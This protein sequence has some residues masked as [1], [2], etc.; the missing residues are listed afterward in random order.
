MSRRA[1]AVG[2]ASA[3]AVCAGLA[4]GATGGG[5]GGASD[6]GELRDVVVAVESLPPGR[7]LERGAV[8]EALEV[9]RIP[10]PFVPPDALASPAAA[11]G[12]RPATMIPAGGYVLGSHFSA[13]DGE[14][15]R[16]ERRLG[17]GRRPVEIT[18]ESA[19]ALAAGA[20][21]VGRRVDVVVTTESGPAGGAGRTYVAAEG[22]RPARPPAGRRR[23]RRRRARRSADRGLGG[24][25]GAHPRAGAAP[26][27]RPELRP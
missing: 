10:E 18:V 26:D 9:R 7:P 15:E 22:G 20:G 2:F 1:R 21:G 16:P 12:R 14:R 17:G 6:Y 4:A 5:P 23:A 8:A 24:D 19:G 13:L 3:A 25:A 11:V 27:P